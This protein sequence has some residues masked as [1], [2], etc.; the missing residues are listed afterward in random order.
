M[1][2]GRKDWLPVPDSGKK[3]RAK[4]K[5][6][7]MTIPGGENKVRVILA[8]WKTVLLKYAGNGGMK[9]SS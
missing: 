1:T 4:V 8:V 6:A 3:Q 5:I 9:R 7:L 2:I